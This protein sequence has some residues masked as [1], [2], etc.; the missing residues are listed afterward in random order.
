MLHQIRKMVGLVLAVARNV[1]SE[2]VID[3]ALRK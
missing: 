1:I 3:Y 2:E